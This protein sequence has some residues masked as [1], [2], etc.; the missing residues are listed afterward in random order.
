MRNTPPQSFLRFFRWFC[1]PKLRNHIE[2]DLMELYNERAKEFGKS[3]AD[4]KFI[5]DVLLLFRPGII[6][7]TEGYKN[8]NN[9]G[10]F[11]SYF[12]IGWRSL[13]RNK[14]Y[15]AINIGGL[16]MGM[17]VA[18][19]IGLWVHNEL[20]Y[21]K[22]FENYQRIGGLYHNLNFGDKIFTH[23][24]A[25]YPLGR[26]LK[27]NFAE[28]DEVVMVLGPR[29][30]VV[31]VDEKKFSKTCYFVDPAFTDL[32]SLHMLQGTRNGLKE[33]HSIMLAKSFAD[34]FLDGDAVGKTIKFDNRDN[35]IVSGVFE[36]FPDNSHFAEVK[37]LVPI[38]YHFSLSEDA[39]RQKESWENFDP[40][41]FVLLNEKAS[42]T[43]T[44][45]KIKN[46]LFQK[47]PEV[48]KSLKPEAV[49]HPMEK[50]NLYADFKDGK[51]AGGKIRFAWMFGTVGIF[52]LMLACINFMNLS[53]ARGEMRSKEVGIRKVM[54]SMRNQLVNQFMSES[55]LVV[56]ISFTLAVGII[57]FLLPGFN[58]LAGT[59][60][61][62]PWSNYY[63]IASSLAFII[64]TG[65]L[66]GSYPAL[67]LS[68]F[69]PVKVLKGTFK[70]GRFSS[71]P[72]KVLV[73]FQFTISTTL[74]IGTVV[75]FQQIQHAK[76]RSAGF[77]LENII[78]MAIRTEDLGKADY[79]S[80]RHDL[81]ATGVVENMAKSDYPI[82][83]NASS[84]VAITWE[85]KDPSQQ[86]LIALN[87][88]S[89]DFP[90][91]NGFQF[92]EGRDFSRDYGTD[93]SAL[94]VNEL[95]A[96]LISPTGS[97]L[98][99]K[100]KWPEQEREIIGVI[101]DQ[102][103]WTPFVKQ[104]PHFYFIDYQGMGYL[105]IRIK[106]DPGVHTA[107]EKIQ[108]VLKKYDPGSPFDY[109]FQDEDYARLFKA[110]E[111]TGKLASVFSGLAIFIS[112]IGI[113][114]LASFAAS[115]RTKEI[116][117]RKVLG[118]SVFKVWKMLSNDFVWLVLASSALA[119]PIAYYFAMQ[120]LQQYE[121][122]IEI[123][124]EI[125]VT[126]C[127]TL[128]VITM[129]TVSYQS[130]KAALANPVESLRSE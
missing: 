2:G 74:I 11:K 52:V 110:E 88:C 130:I 99:K 68:S 61:Q 103:R 102:V 10:M 112:C 20:S 9:Y 6:R 109:K 100:I 8:L 85:G 119:C 19:L 38:D 41:C 81:L 66:A 32:F 65:M 39:H 31:A 60:I 106:P 121:Y 128:F 42:W 59:K 127:I 75:V 90:G 79:N 26:E 84:N 28:F 98:G 23:D 27:N 64:L 124:W 48:A 82:T 77:D 116:G 12:K 83:G 58:E 13:L 70:V 55:L 18:L 63:F 35:L 43:E 25:P 7:P 49:L 47:I 92:V 54:G 17:T 87:R 125:F 50:W 34:A 113:F 36:D 33:V 30:H 51:N 46:F 53:T 114:G 56:A 76:N 3:K 123:S 21:N 15:S 111:R 29:D 122:R 97:A 57:V 118:A 86:P 107:L 120:W 126:T 115:Q 5:T 104:T 95:A 71:I 91:T 78:H 69:N 22:S 101:K 44:E 16:A 40:G 105:T 4:R 96:K 73:V 93:S 94:I 37:I 1:H 80:L 89:H 62:I 67:Y 45:S 108:V 72:R 14:A 117:I 24:G 129:I